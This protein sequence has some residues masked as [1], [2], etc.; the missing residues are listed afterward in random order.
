[1]GFCQKFRLAIPPVIEGRDVSEGADDERW[2]FSGIPDFK[3][4][5]LLKD[6]IAKSIEVLEEKALEGKINF[7]L[8][9]AVFKQTTLLGEPIPIYYE[10]GIAKAYPTEKLPIELQVISIYQLKMAN[11]LWLELLIFTIINLRKLLPC[12]VGQ[13][14][15]GICIFA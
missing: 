14:L 3:W 4:S 6:A 8:R 13:V 15:L 5:F 2:N 7:R 11:H 1:M 12:R 10:D 9:D